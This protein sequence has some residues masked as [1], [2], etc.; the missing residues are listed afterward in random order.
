MV[1]SMDIETKARATSKK[2]VRYQEHWSSKAF[3][4]FNIL[5]MLFLL[6][7]VLYP[8]LHII[9]ISF[10]SESNI[11]RNTVTFYPKDP[12]TVNYYYILRDKMVYFGY[13]NSIFYASGSTLLM[14]LFTS[15]MA[16]PL[17]LPQFPLK[18][19][20]T[21][22]LSITM[23]FGGGL[24]PTY[25][26]MDKLR[27]ID[28]PW[29]MMIPGCVSAMNVFIFRTFFKN[30]PAELRESA[31][32]DGAGHLSILFRIVLP[33]SKALLATF[34]LFNIVGVW[35]SWFNGLV[36]LKSEP[37]YPLQLVLRSYL[38]KL[39]MAAIMQ[40]AGSSAA[41]GDTFMR[42]QMV[43]SKGVQ[44]AMIVVAMFPVMMIYPFFQRYFVKGVM[45]GAIKG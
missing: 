1:N 32:L 34:A 25:V 13:R 37:R 44:M 33:L 10:S 3:D 8:F 22:F 16:Y 26:L 45:I 21:I 17:S 12:N 6:V 5:F 19:F 4:V 14:L 43:S 20:V 40:R 30:I 38:Y 11:V 36:F 29:V 42:N 23:F 31:Q 39:D 27:L 7:A 24:I 28:T 15:L 35:N 18:R 9:A 2:P 41:G